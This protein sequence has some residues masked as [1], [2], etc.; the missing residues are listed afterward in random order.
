MKLMMMGPDHAVKHA[1]TERHA[2]THV[3][4][5][6]IAVHL[7]LNRNICREQSRTWRIS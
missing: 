6:K 5:H 7:P 3:V 2:S 4:D 1:G